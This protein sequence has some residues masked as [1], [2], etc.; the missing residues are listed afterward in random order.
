MIPFC[1]YFCLGCI[2]KSIH[3][4]SDGLKVNA[5][6][7]EDCPVNIECTVVGSIRTGSHEMFAGKI[8][9]IHGMSDIYW[10]TATSISPPLSY[11]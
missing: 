5:P 7:L 1:G 9:H 3:K 8:E 6:V 4:V 10:R 11:C 2:I